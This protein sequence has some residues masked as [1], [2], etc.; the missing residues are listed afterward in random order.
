[1]KCV[2]LHDRLNDP[3]A[4]HQ[5]KHH[6][7]T[8]RCTLRPGVSLSVRPSVRLSVCLSFT[9]R[10]SVKTANEL[11]ELVFGTELVSRGISCIVLQGN[12][13]IST[14]KGTSLWNLVPNSEYFFLLF[15]HG[16]LT[17]VSVVN[18]VGL[19]S[20]QVYHTDRL[21]LYTVRWP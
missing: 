6:T 11:T 3:P 17:V 19:R 18:L 20:S 12:A 9:S 14:N 21:S 8:A 4:L 2:V 7:S 5:L 10:C 15:R 1:V 13:D 16:K